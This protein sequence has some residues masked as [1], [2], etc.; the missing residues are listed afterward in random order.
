MSVAVKS[1]PADFMRKTFP[2]NTKSPP[3]GVFA[4]ACCARRCCVFS[5]RG[6]GPT[7]RRFPAAWMSQSA[8]R[9]LIVEDSSGQWDHITDGG[10]T[11][12]RPCGVCWTCTF[13]TS[14]TGRSLCVCVCVYIRYRKKMTSVSTVE[15]LRLRLP[16][17]LPLSGSVC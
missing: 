4:A 6:T 14:D 1:L 10:G 11:R 17:G 3:K 5:S 13:I 2:T 12:I 8:A 16:A 15:A 9:P 7:E